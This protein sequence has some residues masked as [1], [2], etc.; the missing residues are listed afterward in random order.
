MIIQAFSQITLI[1]INQGFC[2]SAAWARKT[3]KHLQ[4]TEGLSC[5]E[6]IVLMEKYQ[7]KRNHQRNECADDSVNFTF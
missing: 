6:M 3:A 4:R 5:F 2:D 1:K 7:K